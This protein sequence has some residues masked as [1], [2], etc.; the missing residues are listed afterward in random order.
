MEQ[1]QDRFRR[2]F[3]Q[4][5]A[6]MYLYRERA[7]GVLVLAGANPAADRIIGHHHRELLGKPPEQAFP[8]LA[9]TEIPAR[10]REIA[11]AGGAFRMD[12]LQYGDGTVTGSYDFAAFQIAPG[13]VAVMFTEVSE[14]KKAEDARRASEEKYRILVE[15]QTDLVLKVDVQGR[16]L[17]ASPSYCRTFGKTEEEL[18]GNTF[19]PL[20][21][22]DD[23]EA[24][25]RAM[26]DI[27]RPPHSCYV[28]QRALT[29]NGWR[30][31]AW[32]DT[33][34]LDANGAVQAIIGVGR[35]ITDRR[36]V[37]ERLRSA[38]KLEAI[39]RLAGGVAHD[40][41]NQLTGIVS[42]AE[43]LRGAL[44]DRPELLDVVEDLRAA[45]LRSAGLTRQLLAFARK[46]TTRPV[47]VDVA[48]LVEEVVAML[49]RSV[50]RRIEIRS[51]V[52]A[53]VATVRGAPDRLHAALLNLALNARDAMPAGGT[54]SI[55]TS[56]VDLDEARCAGLAFDVEPGRHV[57]ITVRDTGV[58][59]SDEARAHLFE[60]FFTTKDVG[61]GSG[62]GLAEVYGTVKA[63]GGAIA[64]DSVAGR[65]TAATVWLP[66]AA[67]RAAPAAREV[68]GLASVE[69][70]RV[71]VA[72]DEDN[73]RK[74]LGVLLRS[75]GHAVTECVNG[76][77]AIAR[78]AREWQNL[79][80]V[81]L[82]VMMPDMGGGEV[83]AHLREL[84]PAARVVISS[85]YDAGAM[86]VVRARHS[87][88]VFLQKPFTAEQLA[89]ALET[90]TAAK[91]PAVVD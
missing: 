69:P 73:V 49:R 90:A 65:G 9:A 50:D 58:G 10:F 6:G 91:A 12:Q 59:F 56:L 11:R 35:D 20:V 52:S 61:R 7:D 76:R 43:I 44:R 13:E 55:E 30:W 18:L 47:L 53:P 5:P 42:G 33:A 19:M 25:L 40:F 14:R 85:G 39:G 87:D 64:I 83:L 32:A 67:G 36:R 26:R 54:L 31:F 88:V 70:L 41:N 71:L 15:N 23:R 37:E 82:D 66:A 8:A 22:A 24:A 2:I 60:P 78:Y 74:T 84:N 45:A 16:Y 75:N 68:D 63:H 72:D 80:V 3:E 79:D 51:T 89:A 34:V 77:D 1:E 27:E 57:A 29:V 81:I 4:V 28:E 46:S 48:R 38:E 62:L 21:H 86:D 17:F